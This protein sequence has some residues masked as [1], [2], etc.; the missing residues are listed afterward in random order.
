MGEL[1]KNGNEYENS[2]KKIYAEGRDKVLGYLGPAHSD[3]LVQ[4]QCF[5]LGRV[6]QFL[7]V[8]MIETI[9][10]ILCDYLLNLGPKKAG[11]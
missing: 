7:T 8:L 10:K 1:E 2:G 6:G 4:P 9:M 3:F 11:F 5:S